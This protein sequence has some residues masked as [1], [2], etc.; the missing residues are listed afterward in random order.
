MLSADL[1]ASLAGSAG[2]PP[3]APRPAAPLPPAT[4]ATFHSGRVRPGDAFFALPGASGH[5]HDFADAALAAGAA[6]VVSDRPHPRG[7]LVPDPGAALL[8]LG[9]HARA[10]LTGP[11]VAIS[12]SA[13]KTSTKAFAAAA[14][15]AHASPGNF[16]TPLALACTL[17]DAW[18]ADPA[19]PLVLE[20][21]IDHPGEMDELLQLVLPTHGL[22][23]SIGPSHLERLGNVET[24]AREKARL[25]QVA[26]AAFASTQ[27]AAHLPAGLAVT[28]YGLEDGADVRGRV[29]RRDPGGLTLEALGARVRLPG[30][31]ATVAAVNA[32]GA[33]ALS[34]SLGI[35]P[36]VAG[37]RLERVPAEPGRLEP[38]RV[39]ARLLLDDSYN[40]NPASAAAA[41]EALRHC[42]APR[43]AVLGD[44]LELGPDAPRLHRELG[45]ATRDLDAVIAV[46]R[47]GPDLRAGNPRALTAATV[48]EALTLLVQ[49]PAG[50]TV[51]VKASRGLRFERIVA[52][53]AA[54]GAPC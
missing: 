11:V 38:K 43:A 41:L 53:L 44:M 12:G 35:D 26:G 31:T 13:G 5:G 25:L 28:T 6:Y 7:V 36:A 22:L 50:G 24:V 32:L 40:S 16:N 21:G 9:R 10:R 30:Q 45:R 19:R 1:I 8:A 42:P 46:G 23:T 2:H 37:A 34:A 29:T 20:L 52:A 49:L 27:A 39:G 18:L 15:D 3:A 33:L 17:T 4:G 14:L 54:E 51:L 47:H 48:D